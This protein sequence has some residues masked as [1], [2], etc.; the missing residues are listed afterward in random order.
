M[1]AALF[2]VKIK[3]NQIKHDYFVFLQSYYVDTK[4]QVDNTY[5]TTKQQNNTNT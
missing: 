1:K 2:F 4:Q 5:S 3:K